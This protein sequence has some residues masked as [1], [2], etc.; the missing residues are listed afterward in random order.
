VRRADELAP[1]AD[2]HPGDAVLPA[3]DET[4]QRERDRFPAV[5]G[6]VELVAGGEVDAHVVHQDLGAGGGL[7]AVPHGD[8][9]DL[10]VGGW[11]AAREVDLGLVGHGLSSWSGNG[12]VPG[13]GG[14]G[15][16]CGQGANA[17]WTG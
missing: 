2:L 7:D 11:L 12:G 8:V 10:Q 4:A 13:V 5:P 14:T 15:H 6:R 9:R 17:T 3:L 16:R 1:A